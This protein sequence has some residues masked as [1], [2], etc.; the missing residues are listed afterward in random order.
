MGLL[1][2]SLLIARKYGNTIRPVY[3]RFNRQNLDV[4]E[5]LIQTYKDHIG[6]K[7]NHLQKVLDDLEDMGYDYRFVRGLS[8]LLERCCEFRCKTVVDPLQARR[9]VFQLASE[10]GVPRN[11]EA[12]QEILEEAAM[13]L[14][15][16]TEQL[17]QSLYGDLDDEQT[18]QSF[19]P[20]KAKRLIKRYNLSLTQTL[21]FRSTEMEFTASGNWQTIFRQI[22]W[23]GLIYTIQKLDEDYWV[24]VDGPVSLFKLNR[25]YGTSLAKLLPQIIFNHEWRI[26]AKILRRKSDRTLL[27]LRLDSKR[28]GQYF[29]PLEPSEN[30]TYDS[31][32]EQNFAQSFIAMETGWNLTRE[33]EPIPVGRHVMIPDFSF[34]KGDAKVYMEVAGFWTPSYL[35]HKLKQLSLVRNV[36]MIVAAD[37]RLACQKLDKIGA[38]L[39]VVYYKG[40][41]PLKPVLRHLK[42]IEE[43]LVEQQVERMQGEE[44]IMD[45]PVVT[46]QELAARLGVLEEAVK[47]VINE[48]LIPGYK[49]LGD[50]L[51]KQSRLAK[52]EKELERRTN[53]KQLTLQEA[54]ELIDE[55]GGRRPTAIL[56]TLGYRI[57]W[58]GINPDKAVVH[59]KN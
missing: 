21:L 13:S 56:E 58:H 3:A 59:P 36:D 2:S 25:R 22:R 26:Q 55:L 39:N 53:S 49:V 12:R 43:N 6:E 50:I 29:E 28:H 16:T 42:E 52:I 30:R 19:N 17:E 47:R 57:Q 11:D 45:E 38:K 31:I 54:T 27:N 10:R 15:I 9:R 20:P 23:L 33:P 8:T 18:L 51:I 32:V 37:E 48:I 14:E 5:R 46:V 35:R 24:S 44:F 40:E 7:K 34:Q 41:V 1:P 4:A